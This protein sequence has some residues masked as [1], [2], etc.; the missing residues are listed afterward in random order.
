M[1][2]PRDLLRAMLLRRY[3]NRE[4]RHRCVETMRKVWVAKCEPGQ[5]VRLNPK[6]LL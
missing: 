5:L 2:I 4:A 3:P 6:L 1:K